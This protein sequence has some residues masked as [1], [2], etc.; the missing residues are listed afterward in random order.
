MV[1]VVVAAGMRM[2]IPGRQA[3]RNHR[4]Q[5]QQARQPPEGAVDP[6]A[7]AALEGLER[8]APRM[9]QMKSGLKEAACEQ[10]TFV[11]NTTEL[12]SRSSCNLHNRV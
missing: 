1:V 12:E 9:P 5:Q 3:R 11:A 7:D 10:R 6:E 2:D 8:H 4:Y